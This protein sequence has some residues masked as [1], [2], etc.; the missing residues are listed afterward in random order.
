[1]YAFQL[2]PPNEHIDMF[3]DDLRTQPAARGWGA[4]QSSAHILVRADGSQAVNTERDDDSAYAQRAALRLGFAHD[5]VIETHL[6]A[7]AVRR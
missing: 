3:E 4:R 1:M 2:P 5:K 6:I 7:R